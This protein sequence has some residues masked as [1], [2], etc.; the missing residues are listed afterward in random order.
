[1]I[2]IAFKSLLQLAIDTYGPGTTTGSTRD[3]KLT[4]GFTVLQKGDNVD[5][6]RKTIRNPFSCPATARSFILLP[7]YILEKEASLE[8]STCSPVQTV[9][10]NS[11][12]EMR[13]C[14]LPP[15]PPPAPP[16]PPPLSSGAS[17]EASSPVCPQT[18]KTSLWNLDVSSSMIPTSSQIATLSVRASITSPTTGGENNIICRTKDCSTSPVLLHIMQMVPWEVSLR[19]HTLKISFNG[20]PLQL[21]DRNKNKNKKNQN[22]GGEAAVPWKNFQPAQPRG[23]AALI[24]ILLN[25]PLANET[26]TAEQ[27]EGYTCGQEVHLQVEIK[28]KLLTIFDFPPDASRGIDVPAA[29]ITLVPPPESIQSSTKVKDIPSRA[30]PSPTPLIAAVL[31]CSSL[32]E[33]PQALRRHSS[34]HLIN[35]PIPDASMPFNVVCFTSTVM[36]LAFGSALNAIL[37]KIPCSKDTGE[38]TDVEEEKYQRRRAIKLRLLRVVA[39]FVSVGMTALYMDKDL[40]RQADAWLAQ[41]AALWPSAPGSHHPEL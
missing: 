40:Q 34:P 14:T 19:W 29:L 27:E 6:L 23:N 24:E 33:P 36:A 32:Q 41:V 35:L 1:M 3:I 17:R 21:S 12:T 31:G 4:L 8:R 22:Q 2:E 5:V 10:F 28:K 7:S 16:P 37:T 25:L 11:N 30:I 38:E 18:P 39:V 26:T 15:P 9:L 20:I 13:L